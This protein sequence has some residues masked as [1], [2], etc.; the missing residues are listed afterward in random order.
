MA[1]G[2]GP[3]LKQGLNVEFYSRNMLCT[4]TIIYHLIIVALTVNQLISLYFSIFV[5]SLAHTRFCALVQRFFFVSFPFAHSHT[6]NGIRAH[7]YTAHTHT[8]NGWIYDVDFCTGASSFPVKA[9]IILSS[10]SS[11]RLKFSSS[12][13]VAVGYFCCFLNPLFFFALTEKC[14]A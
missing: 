10:A 2:W 13:G 8:H 5:A 1:V 3:H 6:V 11:A 14:I 4:S 12:T 9:H 7:L